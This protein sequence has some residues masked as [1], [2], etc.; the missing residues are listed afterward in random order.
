M[1]VLLKIGHAEFLLPNDQGLSTLAKTFSKAK[2]ADL[3]HRDYTNNDWT[4][5]L[6]ITGPA[7]EITI[8]YL[9]PKIEIIDT[10]LPLGLPEFGTRQD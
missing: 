7:P 6:K 4:K 8:K 2:T 10:T 1:K 5:V 3:T 9:D